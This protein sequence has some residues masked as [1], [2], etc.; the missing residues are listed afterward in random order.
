MRRVEASGRA[1]RLELKEVEGI[2]LGALEG[3]KGGI[4]W[5]VEYVW[6][7]WLTVWLAVWSEV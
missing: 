6:S 3:Q 5:R 1:S 2:R 4:G 7:G